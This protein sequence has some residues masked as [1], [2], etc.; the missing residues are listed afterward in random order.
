MNCSDKIPLPNTKCTSHLKSERYNLI[1]NKVY[2]N[3]LY[4]GDIIEI[5]ESNGCFKVVSD[6]PYMNGKIINFSLYK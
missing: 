4:F 1:D 3:G 2:K 5:N 6:N